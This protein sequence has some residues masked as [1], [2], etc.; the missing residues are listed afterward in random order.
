MTF[1]ALLCEG[2]SKVQELCTDHDGAEGGQLVIQQSR[3]ANVACLEGDLQTTA[4]H[5]KAHAVHVDVVRLGRL[6]RFTARVPQGAVVL[7]ERRG[8]LGVLE[9]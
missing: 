8:R 2:R 3:L 7:Y 4:A 1:L 5:A 9:H 6:L